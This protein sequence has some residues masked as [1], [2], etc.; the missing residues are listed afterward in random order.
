MLF[1]TQ[2]ITLIMNASKMTLF[3]PTSL[4]PSCK[5]FRFAEELRLLVVYLMEMQHFII[6]EL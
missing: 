5:T 2:N 3:S 1:S 6:S 4:Y